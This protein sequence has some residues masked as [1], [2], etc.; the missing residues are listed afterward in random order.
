MLHSEGAV[1]QRTTASFLELKEATRFRERWRIRVREISHTSPVRHA[2]GL[3]RLGV[4]SSLGGHSCDDSKEQDVS[5]HVAN[6]GRAANFEEVS[7]WYGAWLDSLGLRTRRTSM[8]AS[9]P[10]AIEVEECVASHS[11]SSSCMREEALLAGTRSSK[12]TS[13]SGKQFT[14]KEGPAALMGLRRAVA[15]TAGHGHLFLTLTDN[16]SSLLAFHRGRSCSYDLLCL[17]RRAPAL[18]IGADVPWILR[19]LETWRNP[20]DEGSRRAPLA[21]V[22]RRSCGVLL[23]HLRLNMFLELW[24]FRFVST[25]MS[26]RSR[27]STFRLI[28]VTPALSLSFVMATRGSRLLSG[29]EVLM[30]L[31][32]CDLNTALPD[33]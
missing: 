33:A 25:L 5:C 4:L 14:W 10:K 27:S 15:G 20:S 6:F 9:S 31:P 28:L 29:D 32:S 19:H 11:P 2:D 21:L 12:A 16:M 30:S 17:C 18:C 22:V 1:L 8:R 13:S 23:S 3:A 7:T 24:M 26:G